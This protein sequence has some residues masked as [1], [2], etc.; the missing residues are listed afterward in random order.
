VETVP[1][2]MVQT[3]YRGAGG[4]LTAGQIPWYAGWTRA[5]TTAT[6]P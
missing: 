6:T 2:G 5:F 1:A 4:V 3:N